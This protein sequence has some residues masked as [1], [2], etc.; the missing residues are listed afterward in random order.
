MPDKH[1]F[2]YSA[3]YGDKAAQST[4][5]YTMNVAENKVLRETTKTIQ[6]RSCHISTNG[7]Q[8]RTRN[9]LG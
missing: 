5:C 7:E 6:Q 9:L 1:W 4:K 8:S 3:L 2:L